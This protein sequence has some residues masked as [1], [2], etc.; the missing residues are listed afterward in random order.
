MGRKPKEPKT[1]DDYVLT[2][3]DRA[4]KRRTLERLIAYRAAGGIGCYTA[5]SK[6]SGLTSDSIYALYNCMP[7]PIE[8]WKA[9]K[10]G[11]DKL[12]S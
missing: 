12:G 2:P 1:K 4:M 9:L 6:A 10:K 11:L 5:L 7:M 3:K 8:C